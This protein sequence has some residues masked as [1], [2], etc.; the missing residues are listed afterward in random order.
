MRKKISTYQY[1]VN[2]FGP[3]YGE[4]VAARIGP[5]D[6]VII[7]SCLN[8]E[9]DPAPLAYLESIGVPPEH[10]KLLIASHW[11][12]DH[13]RGFSTLVERCTEAKVCMSR[14][15]TNKEFQVFAGNYNKSH[16]SDKLTSGTKELNRVL[17]ILNSRKASG[18]LA[19]PDRRLWQHTPTT[20]NPETVEVWSL[21]PSDECTDRFLE[22]VIAAMPQLGV[23]KFR[24]PSIKENETAIA[25]LLT[26]GDTSVLLGAD[27]EETHRGWTAIVE[28]T[29]RPQTKSNLFKIPHHGSQNGH[30]NGVWETMLTKDTTAI[31]TPYNKGH[32]L[33]KDSDIIR[34][35][36]LTSSAYTT[37]LLKKAPKPKRSS[38]T[39]KM[40]KATAKKI[41]PI[42]K[43]MGHIQAKLCT[44]LRDWTI[45]LYQGAES[46][47][48]TLGE[49]ATATTP[50]TPPAFL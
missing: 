30:H 35:K 5:A 41:A 28:S 21:S 34:I 50:P 8:A 39:E 37:R 24:T 13:V 40:I 32:K 15:L 18:T 29:G 16:P 22:F 11:H 48:G 43:Q 44:E 7:D 4:S 14:A 20:E 19:W 3:G 45:N 49:T 42:E 33:P 6:W 17:Q 2:L 10:V 36:G 31:M 23:T 46:L 26:Y 47:H 12:D 27:L 25:I 9:G 1:E 38:S